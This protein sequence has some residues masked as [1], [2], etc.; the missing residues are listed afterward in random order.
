MFLFFREC[1]N[2]KCMVQNPW[3]G[4][5]VAGTWVNF[6]WIGAAGLSERLPDYSLL[7]GQS[8]EPILV[9]FGQM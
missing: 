7:C 6:C 1:E 2:V 5:G 3:V 9:T 8:L 4:E